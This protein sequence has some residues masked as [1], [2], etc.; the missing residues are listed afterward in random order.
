MIEGRDAPPDEGSKKGLWEKLKQSRLLKA[1][2]FAAG[3]HGVALNQEVEHAVGQVMHTAAESVKD[4]WEREH[5]VLDPQSAKEKVD[6]KQRIADR[7]SR[8]DSVALVT[9]KEEAAKKIE[10][11]ESASLKRL[12]FDLEKL[13]GV[14][15]AE[16]AAA[17][18]KADALIAKYVADVGDDLDFEKLQRIS[19]EMYGPD[20]AADWGQASVTQYFNKGTRNCVGV[21]RPQ[22]IVLEGVL[23]HL[24]PEKRARW[25]LATQ[26]ENQHEMTA[27]EH[28]GPDGKRDALYILEGKMT[29]VVVGAEEEPG[30]ATVPMVDIKKAFV[31]N[32]VVEVKAAG[33]SSEVNS[34]ARID[35]VTDEPAVLN[36]HIEGK[37]RAASMNMQ[38]ARRQGIEPRKM[39]RAEIV[40]HEEQEKRIA[41]QVIE[42]DILSGDPGIEGARARVREGME[43]GVEAR[44]PNHEFGS[45]QETVDARDITTASKETVAALASEVLLDSVD[46]AGKNFYEQK[47]AWR[48]YYG[49]ME[50]WPSDA[51]R[52]ALENDVVSLSV[53]TRVGGGLSK[54]FLLGYSRAVAE[55]RMK[56]QEIRLEH[57]GGVN[58]VDPSPG[59]FLNPDDLYFL[60]NSDGATTI[61]V[62]DLSFGM[63]TQRHAEILAALKAMRS[64]KIVMLPPGELEPAHIHYFASGAGMRGT[65]WV[66]HTDYARLIGRDPR[67]LDVKQVSFNPEVTVQEL[68][69]LRTVIVGLRPGHPRIAEIDGLI[70]MMRRAGE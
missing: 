42:F 49:T 62:S 55:G 24:S 68:Q 31:S 21:A 13:N 50:E 32:T 7:R 18:Q 26:F 51:V 61:D 48:I 25:R 59:H 6:V 65:V 2:I 36:I 70:N 40:A 33:N 11:G 63:D 38:E 52:Q 4:V 15:A 54:N 67:I 8:T 57:Q 29:R 27:I 41:D 66:P 23:Q 16:V 60:T 47:K 58:K 64:D 34:G 10:A 22:S 69:D 20:S 9:Y 19:V 35:V 17:E 39:T 37:L 45:F 53:Q 14:P 56:A 1:G 28:L 3:V 43:H 46:G 5:M 44:R 30:T 12:L